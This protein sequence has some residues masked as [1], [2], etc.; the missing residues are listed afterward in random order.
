MSQGP[1]LK[2]KYSTEYMEQVPFFV[3]AVVLTHSV[4]DRN[5]IKENSR[6][7]CTRVMIQPECR[8]R[9]YSNPT[10]LRVKTSRVGPRVSTRKITRISLVYDYAPCGVRRHPRPLPVVLFILVS[11]IFLYIYILNAFD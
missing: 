1:L 11:L 5:L 4:I 10:G 3:E 6:A 8:L 7:R 9:R 2:I